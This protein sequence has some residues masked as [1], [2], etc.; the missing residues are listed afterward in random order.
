[1][2]LTFSLFT[3]PSPFVVFS[4]CIFLSPCIFVFRA[5]SLSYLYKTVVGVR[6]SI[7]L[8]C[9]DISL[10]IIFKTVCCIENKKRDPVFRKQKTNKP[11]KQQKLLLI[12]TR[13]LLSIFILFC[14]VAVHANAT[15]TQ[16]LLQREVVQE[17]IFR[18][19]FF[20]CARSSRPIL[21]KTKH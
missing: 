16:N 12:I 15:T 5:L 2:F 21:N 1:V 6:S 20:L 3:F 4:L 17:L 7:H 10:Y 8:L 13:L 18:S 9:W 11:K 14:I 19:A